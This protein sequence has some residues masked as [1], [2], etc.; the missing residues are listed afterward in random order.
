MKESVKIA[1]SKKLSYI[2]RHDT[3][4]LRDEGGWVRVEYIKDKDIIQSLDEIVSTSEKNRFEYDKYSGRIRARQGHS[5]KNISEDELLTPLS[6][7]S[8]GKLNGYQYAVHSTFKKSIP[9]IRASGGLSKMKRNHIH[10]VLA[11]YN[12]IQSLNHNSNIGISGLRKN[13]DAYIAINLQ[14]AVT[15]GCTF[16][17]SSNGVLLSA[18]NKNGCIPW[19][20]CILFC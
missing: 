3:D 13:A 6:M 11:E 12:D 4:V 19:D 9:Q 16:F 15:L 20:C 8:E 10:M 1:L 7:D 2:L 18:G 17:L 5:V 14:Q